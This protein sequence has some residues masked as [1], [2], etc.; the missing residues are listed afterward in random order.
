VV[1]VDVQVSLA[2]DLRIERAV[3]RQRLQHV[4]E[5]GDAGGDLRLA[6][7]VEIDDHLQLRLLRLR[8]IFRCGSCEGTPPVS[9]RQARQH[10]AGVARLLDVS[11]R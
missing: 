3:L 11:V 10:A 4:I 7:A 1:L 2:A 6:A 9:A 8:E 5:E